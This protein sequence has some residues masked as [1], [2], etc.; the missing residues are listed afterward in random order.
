MTSNICPNY[1]EC[2]LVNK[3]LSLNEDIY[4]YYINN[5]CCCKAGSW[6]GC[7]RFRAKEEL[8]FC[9][10]FVLPDSEMTIDEVIDR[11]DTENI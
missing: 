2:T 9:P 7:M 11:F 5:Y 1:K 4:R 10:D 6:S 8:N 3:E